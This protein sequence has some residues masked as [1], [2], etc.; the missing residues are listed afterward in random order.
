MPEE[1]FIHIR[2]KNRKTGEFKDGFIHIPDIEK[3]A[4][5]LKKYFNIHEYKVIEKRI[6]SKDDW[7]KRGSL[8]AVY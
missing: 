4:V 7:V 1:L 5:G 6:M 8:K 2:F 3:Y